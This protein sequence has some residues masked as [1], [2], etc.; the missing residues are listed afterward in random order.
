MLRRRFSTAAWIVGRGRV[1]RDEF[2]KSLKMGCDL[3]YIQPNSLQHVV[4]VVSQNRFLLCPSA[5]VNE[6]E[7]R[8]SNGRRRGRRAL[9]SRRS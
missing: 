7:W 3:R 9:V 6:R 8:P 4:D 1:L 5:E 2:G